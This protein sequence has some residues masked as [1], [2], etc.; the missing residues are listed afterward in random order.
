MVH[1]LEE[2]LFSDTAEIDLANELE[3]WMIADGKACEWFL[4]VI[5]ASRD[6]YA[7]CRK[8]CQGA[9]QV[10][11]EENAAEIEEDIF[12]GVH[13]SKRYRVSNW[14]WGNNIFSILETNGVSLVAEIVPPSGIAL[15]VFGKP[16]VYG[17]APVLTF[18]VV[19]DDVVFAVDLDVGYLTAENLEGVVKLLT[20]GW[21]HVGVDGAVKKKDRRVDLVG[22]EKRGM[23]SEKVGVVPRE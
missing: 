6:R 10:N 21:R 2:L 4:A 17:L 1:N 14:Y 3:H 9:L 13:D 7:E 11:V 18:L 23:L 16:S 19:V 22:V 15:E 20:L 8:F 12:E 5:I